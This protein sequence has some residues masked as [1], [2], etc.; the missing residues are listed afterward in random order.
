MVQR[1]TTGEMATPAQLIVVRDAC[2]HPC[3]LLSRGERLPLCLVEIPQT[4]VFH[5]ILSA[6]SGI[7]PDSD[8]RVAFTTIM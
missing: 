6:F 2:V 3:R 7:A 5:R 1:L 4:D 8:I